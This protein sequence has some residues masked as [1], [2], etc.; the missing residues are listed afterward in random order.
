MR[1]PKLSLD[2]DWKKIIKKAWSVRLMI[3]AGFLSGVEAI[4]PMFA[5]F[6]PRGMFSILTVTVITLAMI[7]RVTVQK[8]IK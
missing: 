5:D 3:L 6:F 4:L 1:K 8:D 7:A 2:S